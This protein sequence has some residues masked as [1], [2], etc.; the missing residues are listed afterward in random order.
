MLLIFSLKSLAQIKN[1]IGLQVNVGSNKRANL[2]FC[3]ERKMIEDVFFRFNL[4]YGNLM[5]FDTDQNTGRLFLM[6][7]IDE[8]ANHARHLDLIYKGYNFYTQESRLSAPEIKLGA[9]LMLKK[10]QS[11]YRSLSGLYAGYQTSFAKI[12]QTYSNYYRNDS[13]RT[14]QK[15][16]GVSNYYSWSWLNL[17]LGWKVLIASNTT[18]DFSVEQS[19][20]ILFDSRF[21]RVSD[22]YKNPYSGLQIDFSLGIRQIF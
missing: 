3:Y 12:T 2:S 9:I 4:G 19:L 17:S 22:Y 16:E 15:I 10:F 14:D 13:L 11:N 20:G 18:I 5:P 6:R 1:G 8:P 7:K 21:R